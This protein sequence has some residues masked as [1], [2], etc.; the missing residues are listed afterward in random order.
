MS[1]LAALWL[2]ILLS[3]IAVFVASSIIHMVLQ[4]W[5]KTDYGKVPNEAGAMD[6][7]RPFG[8]PPGDY[9][10]P[11][12]DN[13]EE[14]RSPGFKEKMSKGPVVVMTVF[15]NGEW[16]MGRA[17]SLWFAYCLLVSIL[18]AY[19][20]GMVLP[21]HADTNIV[22]RLCSVVAFLA[23]A[24]ALWQFFVWYRRSLLT[25]VKSTIDGLVYGLITAAAFAWL[26]P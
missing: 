1:M 17:L 9:M 12:C 20:A 4:F 25:T 19:A 6:A 11:Q 16:G 3:A 13:M 23:Y 15:P 8:I 21:A 22:F 10:M 26:W 5:H 7:L 18:T 14:M 2:P 24:G